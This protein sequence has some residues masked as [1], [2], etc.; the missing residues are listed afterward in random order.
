MSVS[1]IKTAMVYYWSFRRGITSAM[2]KQKNKR[3]YSSLVVDGVEKAAA[4]SMLYAVGF[5][6][7][8]FKKPQ[9]GIASTWGI[10]NPCNMHINKLAEAAANGADES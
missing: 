6:E 7:E 5:S 8:D 9:I 3:Q 10:L 1:G 4:R 2:T